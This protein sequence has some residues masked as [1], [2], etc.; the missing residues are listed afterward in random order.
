MG[1]RKTASHPERSRGIPKRVARGSTGSPDCAR[2]DLTWHCCLPDARS[3]DT[4]QRM[5]KSA[6]GKGLSAL[7]ST[8]PQGIRL[9]AE[10]GEKIQQVELTTIVPSPLQPRKNFAGEALGE[11]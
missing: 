6:L 9:E 7:I 8:R 4:L 3:A 2:D 11:L 1:V 5:A 10:P